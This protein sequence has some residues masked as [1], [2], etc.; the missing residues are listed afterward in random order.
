M[1]H[2]V[3]PILSDVLSFTPFPREPDGLQY[4]LTDVD[5][6]GW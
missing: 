1:I 2:S 3:A 5:D 4:R 6:N